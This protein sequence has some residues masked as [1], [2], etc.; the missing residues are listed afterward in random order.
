[1]SY[2]SN[3]RKKLIITLYCYQ[4]FNIKKADGMVETMQGKLYREAEVRKFVW[5]C[6]YQVLSKAWNYGLRQVIFFFFLRS[7][8]TLI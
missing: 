1:M 3:S 7:C 8:L 5:F 2:L 6:H 4:I